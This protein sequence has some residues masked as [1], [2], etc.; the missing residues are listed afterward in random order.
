MNKLSLSDHR[1]EA[2]LGKWIEALSIPD[3]RL[4]RAHL[5]EALAFFSE[6]MPT[7]QPDDALSFLRA[8]DLSRP[9]R[10]VLLNKDDRLIAFRTGHESP[11]KVFY[12]RRGAAMQTSGINPASRNAVHFIVRASCWA[13]ESYTTGA[14]D[15]WTRPE[16]GQPLR[17]DPHTGRAGYLAGGGG[18]QLII[19]QSYNSLLTEQRSG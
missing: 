6:L 11:F 17:L 8:M 19:P 15:T 3:A 14:N 4:R 12:A 7:L 13:L 5:R 16:A 9:V 1:S 2:G 18:V 10:R